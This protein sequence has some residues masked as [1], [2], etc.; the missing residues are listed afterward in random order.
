[1]WPV[2]YKVDGQNF[3]QN[4]S[5]CS[6]MEIDS[7]HVQTSVIQKASLDWVNNRIRMS[8]RIRNTGQG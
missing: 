5:L 4:S 1:M 7:E 2:R 3:G 8:I 6:V